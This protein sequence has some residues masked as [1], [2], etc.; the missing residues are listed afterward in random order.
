MWI[1]KLDKDGNKLWDKALGGTGGEE[2]RA[3]VVETKNKSVVIVGNTSSSNG[4][5]T[6]PLLNNTLYDAWIAKIAVG[7][8]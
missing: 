6:E 2:P 1:V 4:D 7:T 3:N 5:V 8:K